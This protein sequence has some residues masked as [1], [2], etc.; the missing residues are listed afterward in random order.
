VHQ[1]PLARESALPGHWEHSSEGTRRVPHCHVTEP[2]AL[3]KDIRAGFS[4]HRRRPVKTVT[5]VQISEEKKW[6]GQRK[7]LNNI[8]TVTFIPM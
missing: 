6:L 7:R 8:N 4:L 3:S 1:L 5:V 2:L